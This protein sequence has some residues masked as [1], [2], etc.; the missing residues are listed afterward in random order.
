MTAFVLENLKLILLFVLIGS[1][2]GLS[3]LSGGKAMTAR[4]KGIRRYHRPVSARV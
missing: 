3:N 4:P 2:I 1:V